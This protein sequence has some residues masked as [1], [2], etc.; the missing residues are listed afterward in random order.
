MKITT[1]QTIDEAGNEE[2]VE[3]MTEAAMEK[4]DRCII[5]NYDESQLSEMEGTRT[6]LRIF[7]NKLIMT[8]IGGVSSKMEFEE[9]KSYSNLYSTPYGTFDLDFNT[10]RYDYNLDEF[11]KGSVYIEYTVILGG[12]E[13]NKNKMK[14][15]IL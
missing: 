9:N 5:V 14:I 2:V 6:R 13:E 10:T 7:E 8:K 3:L 11:G 1:K 4:D 12:T 15:D